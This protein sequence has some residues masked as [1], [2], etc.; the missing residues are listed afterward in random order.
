M[1][2]EGTQFLF[3]YHRIIGAV[4][5]VVVFFFWLYAQAIY[6][7]KILFPWGRES[8]RV[9]KQE[10]LGLFRLCL[11]ASGHRVG[12][13]SFIHGLGL[14]A[15]TGC[16]LTGIVMFSMIPPGHVGPPE[17]PAAF[18]R[19]TLMHKFFGEALWIYWLGHVAFAVVHQLTGDKVFAA[20]FRLGNR[21]D[22]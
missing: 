22:G 19:Y 17:D 12:L 20:I 21:K 8:R 18:T 15:L 5:A 11:P 3:D 2:E 10:L 13:S 6:D 7:F 1:S 9:V 14:L 16:A 4:A